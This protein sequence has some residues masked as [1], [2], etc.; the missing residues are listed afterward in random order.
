MKPVMTLCAALLAAP[1]LA[2]ENPD[3]EALLFEENCAV[4]HGTGG[5]GDGPMTEMLVAEVPDITGLSAR[6]EGAFPMLYVIQT[7]DGRS[8]M[9]PHDSVMPR[10]GR[11]FL[12]DLF[13]L[14][15]PYGAEAIIRGRTLSIAQYVERIQE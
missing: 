4:C 10:F 5:K 3:I 14:I 2:Q 13:P 7:I 8:G 1:V 12:D 6:N 15:G 11:R 9:R